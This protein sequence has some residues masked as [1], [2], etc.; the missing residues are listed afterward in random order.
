[1]STLFATSAMATVSAIVLLLEVTSLVF[2]GACILEFRA[3]SRRHA[4][5]FRDMGNGAHAETDRRPRLFL[6]LYV[7]ATVLA[8]VVTTYLFLFQP[9]IL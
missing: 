4:S 8:T 9:H 3:V 5:F 6:W 7:A 2:L 1:M